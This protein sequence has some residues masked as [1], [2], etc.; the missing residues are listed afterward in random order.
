MRVVTS[1]RKGRDEASSS[2]THWDIDAVGGSACRRWL[3][4]C[5]SKYENNVMM[6]FV[7]VSPVCHA[8]ILCIFGSIHVGFHLFDV[9]FV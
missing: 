1:A 5:H 8:H 7:S 6:D 9:E 4:Y 3:T 2:S